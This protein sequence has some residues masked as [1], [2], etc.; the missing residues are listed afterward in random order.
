LPFS[1][2]PYIFN[3]LPG[4]IIYLHDTKMTT[5]SFGTG[6]KEKIS[7]TPEQKQ[8]RLTGKNMRCTQNHFIMI[9]LI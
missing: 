9:L 1:D 6:K 8:K 7:L 2:K 4:L 3:G 5:H